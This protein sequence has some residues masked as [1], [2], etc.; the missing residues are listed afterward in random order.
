M[1][2][3]TSPVITIAMWGGGPHFEGRHAIILFWWIFIQFFHV[4]EKSISTAFL[5]TLLTYDYKKRPDKGIH[6]YRGEWKQL[7]DNWRNW[8]VCTL[9]AAN[10]ICLTQHW[11]EDAAV[12]LNYPVSPPSYTML[13]NDSCPQ[14]LSG[15]RA[16]HGSRQI[17]Y[18]ILY[19]IL[20]YFS[21][22]SVKWV[23]LK[24]LL[25]DTEN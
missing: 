4:G 3:F 20:L 6:I 23:V 24:E 16:F 7:V 1:F 11:C 5:H 8:H 21:P 9:V 13:I 18:V 19:D 10:T 15:I 12:I 14:P 17:L 2:I 25:L 22:P